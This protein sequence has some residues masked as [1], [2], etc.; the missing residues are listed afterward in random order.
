VLGV[1]VLVLLAV[2]GVISAVL[3]AIFLQIRIGPVPFPV[4]ALISGVVNALLVWA[5]LYWTSSPRLG[6]IALW[7]FL[8]TLAA[9]TFGGP[10]GDLIF[11]DR[12][13]DLF[14]AAVLLIFGTVPPGVL[15]WRRR[16]VRGL[17]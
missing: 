1:V 7:T 4:S 3:G 6:A 9:M 17:R 15:L 16:E 13:L 5:G 2:D 10:G 8:F 14:R 12:L 11:T